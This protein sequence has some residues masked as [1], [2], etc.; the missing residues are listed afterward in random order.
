MASK[1]ISG[2][3]KHPG[4]AIAAAKAEGLSVHQWAQKH[5]HDKGTTGNRARLALTFEG[6]SSK[7]SMAKKAAGK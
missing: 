4:A 2:A 3:V 1:W 5:Q 7:P 6:M